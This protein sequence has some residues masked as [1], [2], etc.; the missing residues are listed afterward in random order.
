M[1]DI[2]SGHK[3]QNLYKY[4]YQCMQVSVPLPDQ[5]SA[6]GMFHINNHIQRNANRILY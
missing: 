5:I 3:S 4:H 2:I 6:L 1:H